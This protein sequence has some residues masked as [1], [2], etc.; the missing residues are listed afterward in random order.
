MKVPNKALSLMLSGLTRTGLPLARASR[1]RWNH[2]ER[3]FSQGAMAPSRRDSS[4]LGM[5]SSASKYMRVPR[6]V[7]SG[8]APW[9]LL[10]ENSRGVTS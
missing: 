2:P 5:T 7:Q 10:K 4:G 9:G 8:Q 1:I 6:P 3:R